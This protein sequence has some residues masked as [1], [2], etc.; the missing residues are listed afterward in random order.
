MSDSNKSAKTWQ[1]IDPTASPPK[2]WALKYWPSVTS[3][4]DILN[5]SQYWHVA[6]LLDQLSCAREPSKCE[7]LS[8]SPFDRF[9]SLEDKGGVLGKINLR[10]FF[11]VNSTKQEIVVLGVHKKEDE[12][13]LRKS[14]VI[15][16]LRRLD[17]YLN[18][19][20]S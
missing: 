16:I 4:T 1:K 9:W 7:T 17:L 3:E 5:H 8:I 14:I 18:S 12:S 6:D 15:R 13:Q 19:I 10:V 20:K 2:L 11:Y